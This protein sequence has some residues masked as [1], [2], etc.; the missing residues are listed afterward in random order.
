MN[1][2][3][4]NFYSLQ[5]LQIRW[6][7][8]SQSTICFDDRPSNLH[9]LHFHILFFEIQLCVYFRI[10]DDLKLSNFF[11]MWCALL[12][13]SYFVSFSLCNKFIDMCIIF[14]KLV[15]NSIATYKDDIDLLSF[16]ESNISLSYF[17]M[18]GINCRGKKKLVNPFILHYSNLIW[19]CIKTLHWSQ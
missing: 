10:Y 17:Q 15:K 5:L 14:N 4:N 11:T 1:Y 7:L 6:K 2:I 19:I 18:E 12:I 9:R 13:S 3:C 16:V 8:Q